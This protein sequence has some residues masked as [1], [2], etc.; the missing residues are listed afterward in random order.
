MK[1]SG[2]II[3]IILIASTFV[4]CTNSQS[5]NKFVPSKGDLVSRDSVPPV[6]QFEKTRHDFGTITQGEK[7]TYYF[8]FKN[9]GGSDLIISNVSASCGCTVADYSKNPIPPGEEGRIAIQ[10]NSSGRKGMQTQTATVFTNT[11]PPT[12]VITINAMVEV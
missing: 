2:I 6:I 3:Y 9:T 8:K 12:T 1:L 10:F 11:D 5:G 4:G 7:I